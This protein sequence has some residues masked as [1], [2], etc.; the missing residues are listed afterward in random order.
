M[1]FQSLLTLF[2]KIIF[3]ARRTQ[4]KIG[5]SR[6]F[7]VQIPRRVGKR[8]WRKAIELLRQG[9]QDRVR[10]GAADIMEQIPV[11]AFAQFAQMPFRRLVIAKPI[12]TILPRIG[13]DDF[14]KYFVRLA[15][16]A[17]HDQREPGERVVEEGAQFL[18][19][20]LRFR[21]GVHH[22]RPVA[23]AMQMDDAGIG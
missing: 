13:L 2:Q 20:R 3:Q 23:L 21:L 4:R 11:L 7:V 22:D 17:D 15:A 6:A 10:L 16:V 18:G 8:L 12:D 9:D 5:D 19:V 14:A 1:L